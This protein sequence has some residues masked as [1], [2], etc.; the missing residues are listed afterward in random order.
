MTEGPRRRPGG[1]SARVRSDVLDAA[2]ALVADGIE[3]V[4]VRDLSAT[5]GVSEP[6]IYRRWRTAEN[7]LLEA[8]VRHLEASRPLPVTGD[9]RRDL[10]RWAE[11]LQLGLATPAGL[12]FLSLLVNAQLR[13]DGAD[14]VAGFLDARMDAL[15]EL[16]RQDEAPPELTV[17]R[18]LDHVLAPLYLRRMFGYPTSRRLARDLV[19]SVLRSPAEGS[20]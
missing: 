16:L 2:D 13:T 6:T 19:A 8:A 12:R 14:S 17:E 11:N 5:S 20:P 15:A 3:R 4:T 7:V 18:L 10:I 9:L 1:R